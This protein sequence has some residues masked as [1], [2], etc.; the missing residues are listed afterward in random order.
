MSDYKYGVYG[1]IGNDIVQNASQAGV[2][3]VYFGTAP[4]NFL[5]DFGGTVNTPLKIS[6]MSDAQKK[7]G[8]FS[9]SAK[10]S[11][12]TLCEAVAAHFANENGNV[13]PI[14][15]VNVLDPATHKKSTQ[16]SK[17][18]TFANKKATIETDDIILVCNRG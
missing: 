7:L 12:Y 13:G 14:Y 3:P 1:A 9:D 6:N 11:K 10:W 8:H 16:T 5:S 4:V 2:A 17:S 15:V 18:L